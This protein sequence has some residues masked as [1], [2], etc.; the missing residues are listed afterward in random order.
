MAHMGCLHLELAGVELTIAQFTAIA[1]LMST[2]LAFAA[3]YIPWR[4]ILDKLV[5]EG[6]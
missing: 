2:A 4:N 1:S 5:I 6:T 3:Q